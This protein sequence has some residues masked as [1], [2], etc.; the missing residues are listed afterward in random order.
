MLLLSVRLWWCRT[1]AR[2]D[3]CWFTFQKVPRTIVFGTINFRWLT[4]N[5]E[6][7]QSIVQCLSKSTDISVRRVWDNS[8]N[9]IDRGRLPTWRNRCRWSYKR[10]KKK[11]FRNEHP[12]SPMTAVCGLI[13][14]EMLHTWARPRYE[15]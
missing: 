2:P 9:K 11:L 5:A 10:K 15:R 4:N 3:D 8:A 1:K 7:K 6:W 13:T 14:S 12:C